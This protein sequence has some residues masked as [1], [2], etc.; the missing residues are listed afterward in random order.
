MS[1]A[2]TMTIDMHELSDY[3][4]RLINCAQKT[5]PKE[6]KKFMRR[7]AGRMATATRKYARS[8]LKRKTGNYFKSIKGSRAWR[9]SAGNFGAKAYSTMPHAHLIEAGHDIYRRGVNTGKR[10]RA[11][12]IFDAGRASF[13]A[14]YTA[15]AEVFADRILKEIS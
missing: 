6:T 3:A 11:F 7:E 2:G 9:S 15:D 10:T 1:D 4:A 14:R 8:K 13:A 5:M 12:R